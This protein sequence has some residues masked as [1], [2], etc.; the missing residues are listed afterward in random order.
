MGV[1]VLSPALAA[2]RLA[3]WASTP[4]RRGSQGRVLVLDGLTGS[5]KSTLA[6]EVLGRVPG[7]RLLAVEEHVPGWDGL[8]AGALRCGEALSALDAGL[9]TRVTTWDWEVGEPGPSHDLAPLEGGCLVLE[10]CGALAAAA[11]PLPHLEVL[12]VLVTAPTPLRLVR[13]RARDDYDWDVDA[14]QAQEREVSRVW[15]APAGGR[16]RGWRPDV[17]VREG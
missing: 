9:G 1:I 12:R 7:A 13:V 6:A 10:G 17:V 14:W 8:A 3:R 5:G 11:R 15:R 2:R 4:V 16:R